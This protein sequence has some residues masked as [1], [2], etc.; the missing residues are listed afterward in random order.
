VN[1]VVT[2]LKLL[3]EIRV[4]NGLTKNGRGIVKINEQA[5]F[6]FGLKIVVVTVKVII[7]DITSP[8]IIIE[9]PNGRILAVSAYSLATIDTPDAEV[10][11]YVSSEFDHELW[12]LA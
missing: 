3:S 12:T 10:N 6:P 11:G 7:N 4:T 8:I 2:N 9:L 5:K 1:N